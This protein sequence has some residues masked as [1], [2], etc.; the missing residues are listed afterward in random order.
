MSF[1]PLSR[2]QFVIGTAA[3]TLVTVTRRL[4][5]NTSVPR[6]GLVGPVGPQG[7]PKAAPVTGKPWD[8]TQADTY[9][10][11][12]VDLHFANFDAVRVRANG[13][14]L[15]RC[16][17]RNGRADGI[18]VYAADVRIESCRIH[19]FLSG[20]FQEQHDA[21]GITGAAPRLTVHNC[22]ISHCS[23]DG[24]Q[25]DPDR[26]AWSDVL[27][28]HCEIWTGPLSDNSGGFLKGEHPGENGVDTKQ[29]PANPRSRLTIRN[30]IFHGYG[31]SG[32]ISMPAALNVKENVEVLVENCVF[33]GNHVALRLRGPGSRGGA[34]ITVRDCYFYDC[35]IAIRLEDKLE[36]LVIA[37]SH[38]GPGVKRRYQFVGGKP[39]G[40][41][42]EG[43]QDA[44][45][46]SSVLAMTDPA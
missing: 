33:F 29:S 6:F 42:I 2:R 5:A 32:Y 19:H 8:I 26:D 23:G 31:D 28:D 21:H 7:T 41:R 11:F 9:E 35:G 24:W 30:T 13:A 46:L 44:P 16:E 38:F 14:T 4:N 37:N 12:L 15:R 20:T 17:F 27:I 34:K 10:N 39:P 43:D 36:N 25:M 18:E 1:S 40:A 22:E 45:P 3:S